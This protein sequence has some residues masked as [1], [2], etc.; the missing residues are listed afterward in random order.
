MFRKAMALLLV[1][2]LAGWAVQADSPKHLDEANKMLQSL[3]PDQTSYCHKDTKVI[4]PSDSGKAPSECHTDCSGFM[5]ALIRHTYPKFD[6]D[7]FKKWFGKARPLAD[8]YYDT[9]VAKKGFAQI[10]KIGDVQPGDIIAVKYP[11]GS[12]NTGHVMLVSGMP[13]Q[14]AGSAP[15]VAGTIQWEVPIIDSSMSGHGKA[16]TRRK[17]DGTSRTGLGAGVLR[18]YSK[19]GTVVGYSWSVLA[20][21]EYHD[22]KTRPLVIGRLDLKFEP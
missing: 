22:G 14:H 8:S 2:P 7:A 15:L 13:R 9:I 19:M 11:P 16:D 6:A 1:A 4:W 5:D 3:R 17:A 12:D 21:S 10:S 20:A 18:L